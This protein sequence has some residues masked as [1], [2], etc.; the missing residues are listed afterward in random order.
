MQPLKAHVHNGRLLLDEPTDLPEGEVVELVPLTRCSPAAATTSTTR[1]GPSC[2]ARWRSRSLKPTP[3]SSSTPMTCSPSFERRGEGPLHAPGPA[4]GLAMAEWWRENRP[5]APDLFDREL[6]A[7]KGRI[8]QQP[9]GRRLRDGRG[10]VIRRVLLPKTEGHV[11]YS[12]DHATE[13]VVVHI[14]WGARKGRGPK[15]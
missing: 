14:V 6:E 8:E 7:A 15:L 9:E 1:S 13:S 5:L 2:I 10:R 3:G 12:V 4:C 11:Y